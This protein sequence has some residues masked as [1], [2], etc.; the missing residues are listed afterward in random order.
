MK[1]Y[2]KVLNQYSDFNGRARRKEYWMFFLFNALFSLLAI[3]L[4]NFFG[5][6]DPRYGYCQVK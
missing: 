2:L 1:W 6:E 3:M 5:I 4:D